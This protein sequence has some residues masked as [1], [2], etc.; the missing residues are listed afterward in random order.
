MPG[1]NKLLRRW[2]GGLLF[3]A[4][5]SAATK[6]ALQPCV[7]VAGSGAAAILAR[8]ARHDVIPLE[9]RGWS[10]GRASSLA[11]GI[12]RL[13]EFEA[14]QAVVVLLADEPGVSVH[15]VHAVVETWRNG[16]ADLV[17]ARYRDRPGH[18]VL[19][20]PAARELALELHG[21]ES[22]WSRLIAAGLTG[23]EVPVDLP[24]P[25]DVDDPA[26]LARARVHEETASARPGNQGTAG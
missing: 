19:L 20:G 5:V 10:R 15:A 24:A 12:E 11:A 14:V 2:S 25:V 4:A 17:R 9:H 7:V 22:V 16:T 1:R 18:P 8:L 26:A 23:R 13:S 6:A 21:E 3:E